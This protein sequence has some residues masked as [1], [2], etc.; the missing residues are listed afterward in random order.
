M[1]NRILPFAIVSIMAMAPFALAAEEGA[2]EAAA[3]PEPGVVVTSEGLVERCILPLTIT[4]VDGEAVEE[5]SGRYEF[6]DGSHTF[7]GYAQGD[8]SGCTTI[9]EAGIG[10]DSPVGDGS[11]TVSVPAGKEYFLGLD[12]R[13]ADPGTWKIVTWRINH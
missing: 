5:D 1:M 8:F 4:E 2:A 6:E 7:K 9:A 11:S 12:V 3:E 13:K 10:A